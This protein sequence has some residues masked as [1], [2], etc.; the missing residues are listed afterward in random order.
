ML[1]VATALL[2]DVAGREVLDSVLEV[3]PPP[4]M[5]EEGGS[6]LALLGFWSVL[7][8]RATARF[9]VYLDVRTR[10]EGWD[11]QTRFAALAARGARP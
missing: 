6:V 2:A 10:S 7:P 4:S 3:K 11:I 9:F 1:V 5:F 8:I